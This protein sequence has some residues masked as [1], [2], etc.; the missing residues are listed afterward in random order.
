MKKT[1]LVL[2]FALFA[3]NVF[4]QDN[5]EAMNTNKWIDTY[6]ALNA[7]K[8]WNGMISKMAE[9][10]A[11]VPNWDFADYYEGVANFNLGNYPKA[12]EAL[13]AFIQKNQTTPAAF[14]FRGN[15]Y[16]EMK[17]AS[18]AIKDYDEYLKSTPN[19]I[20]TML[21]KAQARMINK[22]YANYI[23][24]LTEVLKLDPKN[25]DALSNRAAAYAIQ[26]DWNAVVAD[27]TSAIALN[28]KPEFYYDRGFAQYSLKTPETI[29]KAIEDFSKAEQLGMITEKLYS[30]RAACNKMLKKY[31]EEVADYTL[32]IEL[33]PSNVNYYY[34]RG[35][36]AFKANDFKRALIDFDKTIELNPKH[37]NA[38]KYR[39]NTKG[40][41]GDKAGQAA[42][43]AK[44]KELTGAK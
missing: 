18:F 5:N 32:L 16:L 11:E 3:C 2:F 1:V 35:V 13:T 38:Y 4:A 30:S 20:P 19:D 27:L 25:V 10:R 29:A 24:D 34:N 28:E 41:L 22:D 23:L 12:I 36:A 40:K 21:S 14:L 9:C 26:K 44:V 37:V 39:A 31:A 8:D 42:D 7:A 33:N 6:S 43:V 15:A 17:E